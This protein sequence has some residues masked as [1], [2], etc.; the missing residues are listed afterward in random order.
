PAASETSAIGLMLFVPS[1]VTIGVSTK[2]ALSNTRGSSGSAAAAT[3]PGGIPRMWFGTF[4]QRPAARGER[5]I[6][7]PLRTNGPR[8]GPY[9]LSLCKAVQGGL[10][11][12]FRRGGAVQVRGG[13][14][15]GR[16]VAGRGVVLDALGG[17]DSTLQFCLCGRVLLRCQLRVEVRDQ[18]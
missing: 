6:V 10:H 18:L 16:R 1:N 11:G 9:G 2:G 14:V 13:G 17:G 3:R 4:Q 12:R 8:G 15:E 7:P 5:F